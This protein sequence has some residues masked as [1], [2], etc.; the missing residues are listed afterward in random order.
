MSISLENLPD[1]DFTAKDVDKIKAGLIQDFEEVSGRTLYPGDPLRLLLLTFAKYFALLRNNIDLSAKQNLLKYADEGFIENI[2]ALVGVERKKAEAAS[3]SIRFT[4]SEKQEST[5]VIPEGTRVTCNDKIYFITTEEGEIKP[6]EISVIV[7]TKCTETGTI[8]NG[9]YEGQ[10][11]KIVDTFG[12]LASVE[13]I[14]VSDGGTD[15]EDI[16][17]YRERILIAPESFSCAGPSGAYE[18]WVKTAAPDIYDVSVASPEAG[19]VEIIPL[20]KNGELPTDEI[21]ENIR[22]TCASDDKRPLTDNVM[23]SS[24]EAVSY[25]ID[26]KY[27][28]SKSDTAS[29]E[30]IRNNVLSAVDSFILWQ[31]EKLGRDINPSR[32]IQL[33]VAA[34][35]KRID[36]LSPAYKK[37]EYNQVAVNVNCKVDY[38]GVEDD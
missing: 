24:P 8:G 10:I 14:D 38:G 28:I 11:N 35:A 17:N 22:D 27:Y 9:Y 29:G 6:G 30:N 33:V 13:N 32:L 23:V 4:L 37:I 26:V 5:V 21:L 36:V 15:K 34:G 20:M 31:R 12:Y 3:V 16:A 7:K 1:I 25:D 19:V 2:G 18:Y